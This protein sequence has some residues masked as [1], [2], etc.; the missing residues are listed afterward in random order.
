MIAS[1]KKFINDYNQREE[2]NFR[3]NQ[4]YSD[5]RYTQ[6]EKEEITKRIIDR[7]YGEN[8][9]NY[10]NLRKKDDKSNLKDDEK[11]SDKIMSLDDYNK[12]NEKK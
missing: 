2:E 6:N 11:Y 8:G 9:N 12:K 4:L 7:L 10:N 5:K 3:R 1:K